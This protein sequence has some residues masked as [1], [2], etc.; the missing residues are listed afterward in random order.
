MAALEETVGPVFVANILGVPER[1][2]WQIYVAYFGGTDLPP[3][4]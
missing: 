1:E 4:V 2:T 3:L